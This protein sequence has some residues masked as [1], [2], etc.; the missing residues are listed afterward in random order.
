MHLGSPW[1]L[2]QFPDIGAITQEVRPTDAMRTALGVIAL[3]AIAH[4]PPLQ[5]R[6]DTNGLQGLLASFGMPG[7]VGQEASTVYSVAPLLP[8]V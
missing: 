1:L 3:P 4:G 6:P 8:P 7:Q 5:A 2:L